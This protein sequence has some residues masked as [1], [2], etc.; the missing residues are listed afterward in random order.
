[1]LLRLLRSAFQ[2]RSSAAPLVKRALDLRREGRLA[3]AEDTLRAAVDRHP[4]DAVAATN[5]A[6]ALLE[7]DKVEEAVPLLERAIGSDP[8]CAAA[9]FNYANVLRVSR[10]LGDAIEHYRAAVSADP[11]FA[12]AP[13]ELMHTQLE[14]C[15][16]DGAQA[17][18]DELR[19][20]ASRLPAADWMPFVSPLTA[21]YLG[22]DEERTKQVAAYHAGVAYPRNSS[23]GSA[24]LRHAK[25]EGRIH[26]AYFSR[27]FRDHAVGH[28]LRHVFA[29][30]DRARF[31]VSAFSCGPDDRSVYRESIAQSVDRFVDVARV[32]DDAAARAIADAGVDVLVDLM[33]HT[34]GNRLGVLSRRPAPVQAHY[35]GYAGTTGAPYIDY[36]VSDEIATP[37]HAKSAFTEEIAYV[38]D[39]FMISDGAEAASAKIAARAEQHLPED[40]YVFCNFVNP[41]RMTRETF[42]LWIEILKHVPDSVLWLKRSHALVVENLRRAAQSC[43]VDA[44]RLIFAER[45]PD[46]TAHLGRLALADLAL[47][48]IGW[49]NGH[50]TTADMLW[51]GLPVL[52]SPG[53]T[54]ASRVATSL[55]CAAGIDEVVATHPGDYV[56]RA[57]WFGNHRAESAALRGKL[58]SRRASAPFFDTARLVR[59]LEQAYEAM[60][61]AKIRGSAG[62]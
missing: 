15:A 22:L 34:T 61:A 53:S 24:P 10:R 47:D 42:A 25:S 54:F 18:A 62:L 41:S 50:T 59:G 57:V 20:K 7:Q 4:R 14:A 58:H 35:L 8:K 56:A 29:L 48:T 33:G 12:A 36:F 3:D 13:E 26:I 55:V 17:V 51:A 27:D 32:S 21:I 46:K 11:T 9:H 31:E 60:F 40:A 2:P 49:H 38:P 28:L 16:W 37:L 45:V 43:G 6:V 1:M 44:S 39:C 23:R 30:H 19:D 52:T 5:L